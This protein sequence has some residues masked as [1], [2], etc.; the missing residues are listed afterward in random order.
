MLLH[1]AF[2]ELE[3]SVDISD[4]FVELGI[5]WL[6]LVRLEFVYCCFEF[7]ILLL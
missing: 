2:E 7:Q 5:L 4:Q 6:I 1:F 3:A